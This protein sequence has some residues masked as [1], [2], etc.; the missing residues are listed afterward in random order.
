MAL[1]KKIRLKKGV[2]IFLGILALF[3]LI[4]FVEA[5]QR[6]Q[7]LG[8]LHI[9]I[10]NQSENYFLDSTEIQRLLDVSADKNKKVANFRDL[11]VKAIES[12]IRANLFVEDCEIARNLR[13]DLFIDVRLS[14]P[15]ARFLRQGRPDFYIDSLGKIMPVSSRFTARV[16]LISRD[17][18]NQ[19]PDFAKKDQGLLRLMQAL[20][21]D[22]FFRAQV[23]RLHIQQNGDIR[24]EVQLGEHFIEFGPSQDIAE[25]LKKIR[26]FY[27]EILPLKGWKA[28]KRVNVK[29]RNQIICQ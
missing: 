18:N 8:D 22:P 5:H 3:V 12:R 14:R 28:Y 26:I 7:S 9:R 15:M 24:I 23:S 11:S 21:Q 20:H 13:G 29:Y 1:V 25:K 19:L 6:N 27:Q 2:K 10:V 4:A 16:P 17:G